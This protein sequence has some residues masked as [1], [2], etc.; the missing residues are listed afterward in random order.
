MISKNKVGR[1]EPCPCGSGKKYKKC[2]ID[3]GGPI[4]KIVETPMGVPPEESVI[5]RNL[6]FL[7]MVAECLGFTKGKK[8]T[9]IKRDITKEQVREIFSLVQFIWPPNT[10]LPHILPKPDGKLRGLFLGMQRPETILRNIVRYSLY[11]DEI[12]VISPF[13]N[14]WCMAEEYNPILQPDMYKAESLKLI[15]FL[16]ALEPWIRSGIVNLIPD[17]GDFDYKLRKKTWDLAINRRGG[18]KPPREDM[19]EEL[20][21]A[22]ADLARSMWRIPDK[23]LR[24]LIKEANPNLE[25]SG[26]QKTLQYIRHLQKKDPLALEQPITPGSEFTVQHFSANLEMGLYIAQMTGAYLFTNSKVRWNEILSVAPKQPNGGEVWSPLTHAFQQ[27]DFKFLNDVSPTFAYDMRA[28]E[29]LESLRVLLRK[30]WIEVG[31]DPD[32]NKAENLARDFSDELK[33]EMKKAE[34]D[35]EKIDRDLLKWFTATFGASAATGILTGGLNWELPAMGFAITAVGE[36]LQAR[37][38]RRRFRKSVPLSVFIDLKRGP[39]S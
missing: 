15:H 27:L 5:K 31:G 36:L 19:E 2:C 20:K 6:F 37:L 39:R 24:H 38:D 26:I 25:E 22:E 21:F 29:R 3:K 11:T 35:W 13:L 17:P 4:P 34:A 18:T 7:D 32:I 10:N 1:N 9:D 14:P 8:W 16:G 30:I 12:L 23:S 33:D 28:Q